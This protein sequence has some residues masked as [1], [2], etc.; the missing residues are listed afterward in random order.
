MLPTTTTTT[1]DAMEA[2][3]KEAE[4][5][6]DEELYIPRKFRKKGSSHRPLPSKS[7]Y[8]VIP[9][10]YVRMVIIVGRLRH[11]HRR[12]PASLQ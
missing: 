4:E 9:Q 11:Q 2:F 7:G 3:L 1:S 6:E 5:D 10:L 8:E 12:L